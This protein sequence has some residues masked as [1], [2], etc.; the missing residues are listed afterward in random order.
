MRAVARSS[1]ITPKLDRAG[2][3]AGGQ[4]GANA[5]HLC[6]RSG[7]H[8]GCVPPERAFADDWAGFF[9]SEADLREVWTLWSMW[10]PLSGCQLGIKQA[11]KTVVSGVRWEDGKP[12]SPRNPWLITSRGVAVAYDTAYMHLG[13]PRRLDGNNGGILPLVQGKVRKAARRIRKLVRPSWDQIMLASNALVCGGAS[14]VGQAAYLPFEDADKCE[15]IWRDAFNRLTRRPASSVRIE[16]YHSGTSLGMGVRRRV[17]IWACMTAALHTR[18]NAVISEHAEAGPRLALRSALLWHWPWSTGGSRASLTGARGN[19][20]FLR[21][22]RHYERGRR[23]PLGTRGCL[24]RASSNRRSTPA[25][26]TTLSRATG[27]ETLGSG[28]GAMRCRRPTRWAE[29]CQRLRQTRSPR[30]LRREAWESRLSGP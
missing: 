8:E 29:C 20:C 14:F 15:A 13:I 7:G 23:R 1:E 16:L 24:R 4:R 12:V 5:R 22:R 17:H 9:A 11:A 3:Q 10:E 21:W 18:V 30:R 28:R 19:T 25:I 27:S 2:D 26:G 6:R